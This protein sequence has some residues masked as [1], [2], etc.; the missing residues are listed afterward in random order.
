ML[1]SMEW[2]A[3][4][5]PA[6]LPIAPPEDA[7]MSADRLER[8]DDVVADGLRRGHMPGCV[9]VV[10]RHGQIVFRKAYGH[11]AIRPVKEPMTTDTVFDLASLTKPIATATSIMM[12]VERGEIE[13]SDPVA[14][15][16]PE[17]GAN[18]KEAITIRQ[19]LTHQGG[20]IPDNP[21]SDYGDGE[22]NAWKKIFA[23]KP[24]V[25][26]GMR[27]VYTDVGF[28]VLAE[29]VHRVSDK[30]IHEFSHR[31]LFAPAMDS[32]TGGMR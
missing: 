2:V 3:L 7:G 11:R 13:L 15:H 18:E 9:V 30:N 6:G 16:V 4:A 26:P 14:K 1:T 29:L 22:A 25:E 12:L 17:F 24:Y 19:L 23:L 32:A 28:I 21:L 10:G 27:F 5:E 31:E 20:L 8:I